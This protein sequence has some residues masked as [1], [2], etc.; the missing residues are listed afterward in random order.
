MPKK[1]DDR[2]RISQTTVLDMGFTKTMINKLLPEPMLVTNPH[3][4]CAPKMKLWYEDDVISVMATPEY[5][6]LWE[7]ALKRKKSAEKAV[8]T[9]EQKTA[10]MM[11]ELADKINVKIIPTEK[12]INKV[13]CQHEERQRNNLQSRIDYLYRK[14]DRNLALETLEEAE[15]EEEYLNEYYSFEQPNK[16]TLQ[17]WVVNYIRHKLT[18]YDGDLKQLYGRTGKNTVYMEYKEVVLKKIAEV[19]PQFADECQNQ[20]DNIYICI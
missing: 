2:K 1:K 9:K 4:S 16:S 20:I 12:L 3:Y 18:T 19:Y 10:M 7:K 15:A 11:N 13:L 5:I 8:E 17:R 6:T 14:Y